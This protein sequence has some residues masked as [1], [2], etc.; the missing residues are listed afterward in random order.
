MKA[1]N[2]ERCRT[3]G[4]RENPEY[5]IWNAMK[6][7][8][9]NANDKDYARYGGRG[10]A[11]CAEWRGDF[12]AFL[13][14]V[15]ARPSAKHWI[16]R[17]DNDR[18][19]DPGNVTWAKATDQARNKS[20]TKLDAGKARAIRSMITS[21]KRPKDVAAHFGVSKSAISH[22]TSGRSWGDIR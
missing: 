16:E 5:S 3:H 19:Y 21:G 4:G 15:G 7:R 17:I 20:N 9:H 11:V 18:G 14:G 2:R 6:S 10:I 8:C 1:L 13:A 22:V 12:S